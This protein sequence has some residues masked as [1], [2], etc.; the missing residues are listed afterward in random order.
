MKHSPEQCASTHGH[1]AG[2]GTWSQRHGILSQ[3]SFRCTSAAC[4]ISQ[5][6]RCTRASRDITKTASVRNFISLQEKRAECF[7]IPICCVKEVVMK[8]RRGKKRE[9]KKEE[10]SEKP[11]RDADPHL[12]SRLHHPPGPARPLYKPAAASARG[13][14]HLAPPPPAGSD[15]PSPRGTDRQRAA[16]GPAAAVGLRRGVGWSGG[17]NRRARGQTVFVESFPSAPSPVLSPVCHTAV[18]PPVR[19]RC[20]GRGAVPRPHTAVGTPSRGRD[21]VQGEPV[22]NRAGSLGIGDANE[23]GRG[24]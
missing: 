19:P 23:E 9:K 22:W 21:K 1:R 11:R 12:P 16:G 5:V 17:L 10:D 15:R 6:G 18:C 20:Y 14:A 8:G 3:H 24:K 7:L 4:C 2:K 13:W